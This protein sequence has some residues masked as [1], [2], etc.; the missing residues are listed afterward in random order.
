MVSPPPY[1]AEPHQIWPD[2]KT[3]TLPIP[4]YSSQPPKRSER[5]K[6]LVF[7]VW[8]IIPTVVVIHFFLSLL[9]T[10]SGP[11]L[12]NDRGTWLSQLLWLNYMY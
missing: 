5:R 10:W 4:L 6:G 11:K 2:E 3:N 7:Y 9:S 1:E 12:K 8:R